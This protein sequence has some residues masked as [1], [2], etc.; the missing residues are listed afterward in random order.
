MTAETELHP[1]LRR[2]P[3]SFIPLPSDLELA[4][5]AGFVVLF[6]ALTTHQHRPTVTVGRYR[7]RYAVAAHAY[8][9]VEMILKAV[10]PWLVG[11]RPQADL[12]LEFLGEF[13][14]GKTQ[15]RPGPG[16]RGPLPEGAKE[17]R[18]YY[19]ERMR[20]LNRRYGPGEWARLHPEGAVPDRD[21]ITSDWRESEH[22]EFLGGDSWESLKALLKLRCDY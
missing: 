14:R 6:R 18:L 1:A 22:A 20:S 13:G 21:A 12:M 9:D 7:P 19:Y 16:G 10:R 15:R 17:R 2:L 5:L 4:W 11:K 3:T 8:A